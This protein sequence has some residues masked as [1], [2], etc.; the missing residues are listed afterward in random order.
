[1]LLYIH[2]AGIKVTPSQ[3]KGPLL[4]FFGAAP[5]GVLGWVLDRDAQHRL[6]TRNATKAQKGGSKRNYTFC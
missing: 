4:S 3:Y 5:W 2:D 6:L 1:M